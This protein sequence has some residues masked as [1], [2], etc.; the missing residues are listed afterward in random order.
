VLRNGESIVAD[1]LCYT[2]GAK[3]GDLLAKIRAAMASKDY[4]TIRINAHELREAVKEGAPCIGDEKAKVRAGNAS[5][6]LV[7]FADNDDDD[8]VK[9][10]VRLLSADLGV[11]TEVHKF[12]RPQLET[13]R[14]LP[15]RVTQLSGEE[16]EITPV[17]RGSGYTVVVDGKVQNEYIPKR[18]AG[19]VFQTTMNEH[20]DAK[21]ELIPANKPK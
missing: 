7:S 6:A 20:P 14:V 9:Q 17:I 16:A 12:V 10:A 1:E 5:D 2:S 13:G 18:D 15:R 3:V 11:V 21:V 8:G 4:R 19:M